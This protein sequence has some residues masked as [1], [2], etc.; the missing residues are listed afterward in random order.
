M[1]W[2]EEGQQ[3]TVTVQQGPDYRALYLDGLHQTNDSPGMMA[4]HQ[5]IGSIGMAVH[6]DPRDAL[7]IGLGGGAT[8]G[9]VARFS[10]TTVDVVELS[11]SVIRG[12]EW[13]RHAHGPC[14]RCPGTRP[15]AAR[16]RCADRRCPQAA[17]T[18]A[19]AALPWSCLTITATGVDKLR[20]SGQELPEF[21]NEAQPCRGMDVDLRPACCGS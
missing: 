12:A 9:A 2:R 10:T 18:R 1:L 19:S 8:A 20:V 5:Q 4:V 15:S 11:P 7:V 13:F 6:R 14:R 21:L 3:A 16:C 17:R